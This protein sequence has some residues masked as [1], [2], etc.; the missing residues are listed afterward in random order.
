MSSMPLSSQVNP[1]PTEAANYFRKLFTCRLLRKPLQSQVP[2][3]DHPLD[4]A[5]PLV[6]GD[7]SRVTVHAL[8]IGLPRITD[9]A[10]DLHRFGR[11]T[12][13]H[14]AGVELS[15]G[16]GRSHAPPGIL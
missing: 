7:H 9:A 8:D 10:V 16:C 1:C 5:G 12:I 14:F 11:D 6:D 4:L 13:H 15:L 2:R 3:N